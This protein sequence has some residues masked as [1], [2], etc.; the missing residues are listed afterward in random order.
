MAWGQTSMV[1]FSFEL[2]PPAKPEGIKNVVAT[3]KTLSS[4]APDMISIT[5]GA[6]GTGRERSA[7]LVAALHSNDFPP[8]TAH[9]TVAGQSKH[10]VIH[11]M[12]EWQQHGV[13][14]FVALRG[15]MPNMKRPF[16]PH[17]DGFTSALD[18]ITYLRL[19]H[20]EAIYAGAYP[21]GHPESPSL[22]AELDH[23]MAKQDAG[24]TALITQY[25]FDINNF[26]RFRDK[27]VARGI[28]IPLIPGVLPIGHFEKIQK[29]SASCGAHIPDQ[30]KIRFAGL[31]NDPEAMAMMGACVGYE[32]CAQLAH[33]AVPSIHLYT[34]NRSDISTTICRMFQ[35]EPQ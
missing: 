1:T 10:D 25:F 35:G 13:K 12:E 5:Y 18:L 32:L 19:H 29:F 3:A 20:A 16:T 21:E 9:I 33:E 30:L 17:D 7:R 6:G 27:V 31:E 11:Q 26:L 15:D 14:R 22:E 4:F 8:I 24:A 28:T 34:L 2:F 23:L